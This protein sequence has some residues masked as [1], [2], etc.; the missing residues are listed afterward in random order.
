[1]IARIHKSMNEKD[2]GFTLI[3]LLVVIIIIGILAA[4]AIPVFMN[5]RKKAVDSSVKSD[6]RTVA[7]EMETYYTDK[8]AYIAVTAN[9]A[10][11]PKVT[12]G[13]APDNKDVALSPGN[14]LSAKLVGTDGYC[15]TGTNAKGDKAVAGLY[16]NS[17]TGGL[18][19]TPCP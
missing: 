18:T 16:Y 6:L 8:Q 10:G 2:K 15:I 1:M 5:Q 4:I 12:I 13:A 19:T 3:E 7:N 17:T 9:V 14:V 11:T